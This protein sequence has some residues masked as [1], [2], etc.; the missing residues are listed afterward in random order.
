MQAVAAIVEYLCFIVFHLILATSTRVIFAGVG[1][2]QGVPCE[3]EVSPVWKRLQVAA[4]ET[5]VSKEY[6]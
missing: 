2:K 4:R 6:A 5:C 1:W 3:S